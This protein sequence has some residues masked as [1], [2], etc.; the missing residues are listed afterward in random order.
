MTVNHFRNIYAYHF[1]SFEV[2]E[3]VSS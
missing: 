2:E 1:F 3:K